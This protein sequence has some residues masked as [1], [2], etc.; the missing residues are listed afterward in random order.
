M[1]NVTLCNCRVFLGWSQGTRHIPWLGE[2]VWTKFAKQHRLHDFHVPP[3]GHICNQ[4]QGECLIWIKQSAVNVLHCLKKKNLYQ[5][6]PFMESMR[7]NKALLY[8]L[9]STGSFIVLLALGWSP[10]LCEQFGIV[11]FPDEVSHKSC[12]I[13][14]VLKFD[15]F[16]SVSW[17]SAAGASSR[18]FLVVV[19][20]QIS[21]ASV[22]R[23]KVE[24]SQKAMMKTYLMHWL[25]SLCILG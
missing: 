7:E 20:G 9:V 4:L 5:G 19:C 17:H 1:E 16:F 6:H 22:W 21:S 10:E 13:H 12:Q 18:L 8:S 11:N 23:R 14:V 25:L 2:R 15:L 3:S 24:A